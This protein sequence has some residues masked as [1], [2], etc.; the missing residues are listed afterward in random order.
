MQIFRAKNNIV[1]TDWKLHKYHAK[2]LFT[3]NVYRTNDLIVRVWLLLLNA[4][5][6]DIWFYFGS[7]IRHGKS[8]KEQIS[9]I[10]INNCPNSDEQ[11]LF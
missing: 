11:N 1:Y 8:F 3:I 2:P 6:L 5:N 4:L 9:V 10:S 7:L